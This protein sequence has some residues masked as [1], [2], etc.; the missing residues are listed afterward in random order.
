MKGTMLQG[1]IYKNTLLVTLYSIYATPDLMVRRLD[2]HRHLEGLWMLR[3]V[4]VVICSLVSS[5]LG[6]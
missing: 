2:R 3:I 5:I 4:L 6:I 1:E